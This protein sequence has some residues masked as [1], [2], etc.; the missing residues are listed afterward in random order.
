MIDRLAGRWTHLPSGR[1]YHNKFNPPKVPGHDDV[2]GEKLVIRD[3]DKEETIRNRLKIFN[4]RTSP[5]IEYYRNR[6]ILHEVD[7]EKPVIDI[8]RRIKSVILNRSY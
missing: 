3:D 7:G 1:T 8:W 4:Q 6:G 5:I 2:T